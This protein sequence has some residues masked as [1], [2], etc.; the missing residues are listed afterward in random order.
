MLWMPAAVAQKKQIAQAKTYIKSGK[1]LDKAENMMTALLKDSANMNN[2]K[3]HLTLFDAIRAQYEQVNEKMYLKQ[4]VDT[5]QLF[6]QAEKMFIA[7][8]RFDSVEA[9]PNKKGVI[10]IKYRDKHAE[11]LND[12]RQNLFSGGVY[13]VRKGQLDKAYNIMNLYIDCARQPLFQAYDYER[14]DTLLSEAAHC[15]LYCGYMM[16]D[17]PK[18]LKYLSLA[19]KDSIHADYIDQY[20]AHVYNEENDTTRYLETLNRGFLRSPTHPFFFPHII[21][22]YNHRGETQ[23][24][25]SLVD[26]A[27]KADSTNALFRFAQSTL[28]LNTGKYDECIA[29]CKQLIEDNDSFSEAYCNIALAYFN[30][31]VEMDKKVKL[32]RS[33]RQKIRQLYALSQPY[34][35]KF[36]ELEPD[37]QQ[38][39]LPVLYTI[40]LNLNLGP[41][42]D[43]IDQLRRKN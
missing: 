21:D 43:E 7:L 28:L 41:Q 20:L 12:Y 10:K 29:I 37:K 38:K 26:E 14:N 16:H 11:F 39:W 4:P 34:M 23:K 3:I 30:Q 13:Y 36:R 33:Q 2:E 24:M 9:R 17:T 8:E 22:Y 35:E 42:F 1:E 5:A 15:T 31:A 25:Q 40:Y 27:L 6:V 18:A 32:T 19:M